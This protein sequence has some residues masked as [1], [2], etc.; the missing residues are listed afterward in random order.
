MTNVQDSGSHE[1]GAQ[2]PGILAASWRFMRRWPVI[3]G[4]ILVVLVTSAVFAPWITTHNQEYGDLRAPNTPP[5]WL[6]GWDLKVPAGPLISW[7]AI[8]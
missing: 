7:A 3:P 2:R 1:I 4:A 5:S 6:L 8:S